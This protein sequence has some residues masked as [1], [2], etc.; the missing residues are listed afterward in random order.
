MWLGSKKWSKVHVF[1]VVVNIFGM[2]WRNGFGA[3]SRVSCVLGGTI[4]TLFHVTRV[5]WVSFGMAWRHDFDAIS[6]D[7]G[8]LGVFWNG[9]EAR[10]RRSLA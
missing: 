1:R 2:T 4:S 8:V 7:S 5:F 9:L 3:V 10:F 6:R